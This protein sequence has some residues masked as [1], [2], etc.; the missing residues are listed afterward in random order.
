MKKT[1]LAY[2]AGIV[3]GEGCIAIH[4]Q[5]AKRSWFSLTVQVTSTNEWLCEY[6]KFMFGGTVRSHPQTYNGSQKLIWRWTICSYKA[7]EF[8][9][10]I[11]PYLNLKRP[12]A[13]LGIKFQSA[14]DSTTRGPG[15]HKT[16]AVM[17]IEEAQYIL[18]RNLKK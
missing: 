10:L 2:A 14:R 6:M 3:D 12:Q 11:M 4:K 18:M 7:S 5:Y 1:D 15:K 17:A 9:Q 8:L 16:D 13:E